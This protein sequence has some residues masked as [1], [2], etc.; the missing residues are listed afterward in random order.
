VY[1]RALA[2]LDELRGRPTAKDKVL[3][4]GDGI[5]TDLRGAH[6]AGLRSVFIASAVHAPEGLS[7]ATLRK[8]FQSRPFAPIAA[9]AAL[10]W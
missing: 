10:A 9:L 2:L 3:A 5:E 7:S 6:V 1:Q 8:L 4:I